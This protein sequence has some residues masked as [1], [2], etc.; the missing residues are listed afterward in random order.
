MPGEGFSIGCE[1]VSAPHLQN[2]RADDAPPSPDRR[3]EL[4]VQLPLVLL[5][6]GGQEGEALR[7]GA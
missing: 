1:D 7:V 5:G 2:T 4:K 3:K 6:S